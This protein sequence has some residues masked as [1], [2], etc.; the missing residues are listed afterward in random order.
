MSKSSKHGP[1]VG[2]QP[3]GYPGMPPSIVIYMPGTVAPY[4]GQYTNVPFAAQVETNTP[5]QPVAPPVETKPAAP[6][7]PAVSDFLKD[8]ELSHAPTVEPT[9][10]DPATSSVVDGFDPVRQNSAP[11]G[12]LT[13]NHV[14]TNKLKKAGAFILATAILGSAFWIGVKTLTGNGA[15][16][17]TTPAPAASTNDTQTTKPNVDIYREFDAATLEGNGALAAILNTSISAE[18]RAPYE[19]CEP[20][21]I[22]STRIDTFGKK[23][24]ACKHFVEYVV[25]DGA[26][27]LFRAIA[28]L[29]IEAKINYIGK[30]QPIT[31]VKELD[32]GKYQ[33]TIDPNDFA[34]K[35]DPRFGVSYGNN[36]PQD[37][38]TSPVL[39]RKMTITG[40]YPATSQEKDRINNLFIKPTVDPAKLLDP[41][42]AGISD[43]EKANRTAAKNLAQDDINK[44]NATVLAENIQTTVAG[45]TD[46]KNGDADYRLNNKVM[47]ATAMSDQ[48]KAAIRYFAQKKAEALGITI[49]VVFGKGDIA[50]NPLVDY[51]AAMGLSVDNATKFKS[52]QISADKTTTTVNIIPVEQLNP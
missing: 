16:E 44:F 9:I 30:K 2:G 23:L 29:G 34:L 48:A 39:K 21:T 11:G 26:G 52:T 33:L 14:R 49:T 12:G 35:T 43:V 3:W 40:K 5:P 27:N 6:A 41:N 37:E 28:G 50:F 24:K 13:P 1:E 36:Q 7:M 45:L 17:P 32:A 47:K 19:S 31:D 25:K 18:V 22:K 51:K 8:W 42:E 4:G 46:M 15:E 10:V 20:T 38:F